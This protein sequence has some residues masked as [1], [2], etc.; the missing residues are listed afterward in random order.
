MNTKRVIICA[1]CHKALMNYTHRTQRYCQKCSA[2]II[3]RRR[4]K[5]QSVYRSTMSKM[6]RALVLIESLERRV[7]KIERGLKS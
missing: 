6:K 4:K 3:E 5:A 1:R 2:Y 7:S